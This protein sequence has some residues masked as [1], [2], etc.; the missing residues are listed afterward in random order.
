MAHHLPMKTLGEV[1]GSISWRF[2][3]YSAVGYAIAMGFGCAYYHFTA[4]DAGLVWWKNPDFY[5]RCA[6]V[7]YSFVIGFFAVRDGLE[8][9]RKVMIESLTHHA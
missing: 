4:S 2:I 8:A 6:G 5:P 1:Y 3:V 9:N 7:G